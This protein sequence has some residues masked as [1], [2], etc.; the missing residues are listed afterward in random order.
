MTI[1]SHDHADVSENQEPP[2]T[3]RST[4]Y[5]VIPLALL[6]I[7]LLGL[8]IPIGIAI[9]YSISAYTTYTGLRSQAQSGV[10][11]LLNV[12]T[13]FTGVKAHP[14]GFLDNNKLIRSR[15]EFVAAY[16]DFQQVEYKLDHTGVIQTI[17]TYF[18]QYLTQVRSARAVSQIGIDI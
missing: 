6:I 14:S 16:I 17:S 11:H 13:I 4:R 9:G 8:L 3:Q 7:L 1:T 5:R 15:Q 10:Q 12:K 18:P 2:H